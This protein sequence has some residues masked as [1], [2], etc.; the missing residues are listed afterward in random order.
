MVIEVYMHIYGY[1]SEFF[2]ALETQTLLWYFR[3]VFFFFLC[4]FFYSVNF[5]GIYRVYKELKSLIVFHRNG[6][7]IGVDLQC[8]R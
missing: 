6:C 3:L 2:V 4:L 8:V 5:G 7:I 1:R